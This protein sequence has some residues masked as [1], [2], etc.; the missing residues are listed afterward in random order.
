M[1]HQ[2]RP[3]YIE[4]EGLRLTN[5]FNLENVR[6]VL[7]FVPEKDDIILVTYPKCGTHWVQHILQL[8]VSGGQSAS[9]F[10]EFLKRTPFI[11]L[12]GTQILEAVPPPRLMKTHLPLARLHYSDRAKYVYVAR[13]PWDCCVSF[14]YH[15]KML[16]VLEYQD[17]TFETFFDLF[18]SGQTDHGDFFEHVM[19]W[20]QRRA[21]PNF[22]FLT[23]EE[24]KEDPR[25]TVLKLAGFLGE[26]TAQLFSQRTDAIE[27]VL[28]MSSVLFM[29]ER[30]AF[31]PQKFQ[32]VLRDDPD[33]VP[34]AM[35]RL[36]ERVFSSGCE[37]VNNLNFIGKGIV[38]DW[39]GH[40]SREQ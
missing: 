23:H 12:L 39:R 40:F 16:P 18:I 29:K 4:L 28:R 9:N 3:R 30:F 15:T 6:Q 27:N 32:A 19:P 17:G 31:S 38:G 14:F 13:N 5:E 33:S 1:Q 2:R 37:E 20:Y 35:K 7:Q 25:G 10:F 22:L 21:E 8:I 11:E 34:D 24:L 26:R 36:F